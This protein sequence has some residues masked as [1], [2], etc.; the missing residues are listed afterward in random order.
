[1]TRISVSVVS[2]CCACAGRAPN[3]GLADAIVV[4]RERARDGRTGP[5]ERAGERLRGAGRGALPRRRHGTLHA[6]GCCDTLGPLDRRRRRGVAREPQVRAA[7]DDS[8]RAA[9]RPSTGSCRRRVRRTQRTFTV[10]VEVGGKELG[11]GQ[12]PHQEGGR[13]RRGGGCAQAAREGTPFRAVRRAPER[14]I[15]GLPCATLTRRFRGCSTPRFDT[16]IRGGPCTSSRSYSRGSSPSPTR[17]RWSSSP[18][19]PSSS[20]PTARASPTSPTPCCGCS[21]SSPPRR[22][23]GQA[24]ED[25]IFAGSSA[26]QA[27]GVAE[28]DLVLDNSDGTLPLEFT[29]VTITRR[30]YRNGESEYL[31]N[32]APARLMDIQDLLHDSGLGRDTH[33]IISQG[34]LDEVLNSRPEDR[35][36]L[37]EEAAGVLKHKKRKERALRKL[38][39]HGRA[40]RARARHLL[41]DR[42]PAAAAPATGHQGPGARRSRRRAARHSN[43]RS[44]STTCAGCSR[45]GTSSP[46]ARRRPTPTSTCRATASPRRSASSQKFQSLLEEKGLFVGDLSEQRR[47]MQSILER[48]D[49]GLLLLEEKGKNLIEQALGAARRSCTTP[50]PARP[51]APA[52]SSG[53]SPRPRRD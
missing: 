12:R 52:S 47:R 7:G 27:V 35:R 3:S 40:P 45:S 4:G 53:S 6:S 37:I 10:E 34:R 32:N 24:M 16:F 15:R 1:M 11:S 21:A 36:S 14:L 38:T 19:S 5:V 2:R 20:V 18:A 49:A 31:I 33:S 22:C 28:V 46:S 23:A 48:L 8:R 30:M 29:E 17:A 51:P 13:G 50:R 43:S 42:P 9:R 39:A 26:R 44:P 25:V 41:R